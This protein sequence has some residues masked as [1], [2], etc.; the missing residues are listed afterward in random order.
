ML[1][2]LINAT[3]CAIGGGVQVALGAIR[4]AMACAT[5]RRWELFLAVTPVV[6]K[7]L[8]DE[9]L[10]AGVPMEVFSIGP[11]RVW[12]G[13][14]TRSRLKVICKEWRPDMVFTVFGPSYV[15]FPVPEFMGF[16]DGFS[17]TPERGCYANHSFVS[18]IPAWLKANAKRLCLR[19]AGRFW[20]ET[21]TAK[22]GLCRRAWIN[23]DCVDVVPNG[24]NAA[25]AAALFG[26]EPEESGDI[27]LLGAGYPHKNHALIVPVSRG[28]EKSLPDMSWRFVVTLPQDSPAWSALRE[29]MAAAGL[30]HRIFNRGVLNLAEC[31]A[32]FE[33]A[34]IVFHPS[35][36]EIFSATYVEAMAAGRPLAVSDRAFAREVCGDAAAYFDPLDATA[37]AGV[38]RDL[39]TRP[40]LRAAHAASGRE[41]LRLFPDAAVK[42]GLLCDLIDSFAARYSKKPYG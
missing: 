42:N 1:K 40:E 26:A 8:G 14:M 17:I 18:R 19:S 30:S 5:G 3:P 15:R 11:G 34:L 39:L 10:K 22:K 24:V 27:L 4:E 32:A 38:L 6:A 29:A 25:F 28:L 13:R 36:L 7:A 20:V 35:L 41:R 16:A 33:S 23:P 9:P 2:I 31:A 21:E 12:G 37:A